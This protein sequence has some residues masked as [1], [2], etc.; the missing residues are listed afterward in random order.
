MVD[1]SINNSLENAINNNSDIS[2]NLTVNFTN[3][4]SEEAAENYDRGNDS[5]FADWAD[6]EFDNG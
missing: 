5:D 2:Q 6:A 3:C 1:K 4:N